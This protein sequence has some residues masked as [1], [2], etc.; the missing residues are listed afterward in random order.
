[1]PPLLVPLGTALVGAGAISATGTTAA[2]LAGTGTVGAIGHAVIGTAITIGISYAVAKLTAP[3]LPRP[4]DGSIEFMQPIP[5]RFFT[6]GNM[7]ISGPIMLLELALRSD[8]K[9]SGSLFKITGFGTRELAAFTKLFVDG[10]DD[11]HLLEYPAANPDNSLHVNPVRQANDGTN[12]GFLKLHF[13]AN[14][15]LADAALVAAGWWDDTHRLR[16]VPYCMARLESHSSSKAA[17]WQEAF[18]NGP[19]EIAVA[20]GAKIYD[21]RKDST[22]PAGPGTPPAWPAG[23]G[24]HRQNDEKTWQW[25][26]N[27]R[28]VC[29]DWITSKWGYQKPFSRIDWSTWIPQINMADEAVPIKAGGTERRYRIATKVSMDEPRSRVLQRILEAGDQ[30]LFMTS[31][32]LIGSRG[33]K[34]QAPSVTLA[35]DQMV[36]AFFQHG[37]AKMDRCNEFELTCFLAERNYAEFELENFEDTND[38]DHK[39]GI[40][41]RQ[42]LELTQVPSSGQAQRLAKIY[43][44]KRSPKWSGHVKTGFRGLNALNQS[45][46][47][48]TFSELHT[49]NDPFNGPYWINGKIDFLADKTGITFPVASADPTA[50]DWTVAEEKPVPAAP[51]NGSEGGLAIVITSPAAGAHV[52]GTVTITAATTAT[53]EKPVQGVTFRRGGPKEGVL[54]GDDTTGPSWTATW[55]TTALADGRY[56]LTAQARNKD[57]RSVYTTTMVEVDNVAVKAMSPAEREAAK[58]WI[59][60]DFAIV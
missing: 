42:K 14:D 31:D 26:D 40:I 47:N 20:G 55:N 39:A 19:L 35:V 33:G 43:M 9:P 27:Q 10:N 21:P 5:A 29:L 54:I 38:P 45:A 59:E 30:Q 52:A 24:P 28:L 50:Y 36:E 44:S 60:G 56:M 1:M 18:P 57:N 3:A 4:S 41:R 53:P 2:I 7:K 11:T 22:F 8:N 25:S 23:N 16:G 32:G 37:V 15:Q 13:G 17:Q 6:Y 48:L 51:S 46:V 58:N 49:A 12:F 34:W